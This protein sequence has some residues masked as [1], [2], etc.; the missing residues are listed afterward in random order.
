MLLFMKRIEEMEDLK[1][2]DDN[3]EDSV[4][5]QKNALISLVQRIENKNAVDKNDLN[6]GKSLEKARDSKSRENSSFIKRLLNW[7]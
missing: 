2:D 3:L 4:Q 7:F 1:I 6:T 5:K